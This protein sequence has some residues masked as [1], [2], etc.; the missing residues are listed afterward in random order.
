MSASFAPQNLQSAPPLAPDADPAVRSASAGDRL[1]VLQ[2]KISPTASLKR[3]K[4]EKLIKEHGSPP[5]VRVTAGGR[6]VPSDLPPLG[7]P[8][9]SRVAPFASAP[10]THPMV[11]ASFQGPR[12][13]DMTN[14]VTPNGWVGSNADGSLCQL[15]DGRAVPLKYEN[16]MLQLLIAA[17]NMPDMR[18]PPSFPVMPVNP[19]GMPQLMYAPSAGT[20]SIP[21]PFLNVQPLQ[22]AAE[23]AEMVTSQCMDVPTQIQRLEHCYA[24]LQHDYKELEKADVAEQEFGAHGDRQGYIAKRKE[25]VVATDKLR[26]LIKELKQGAGMSTSSDEKPSSRVLNTLPTPPAFSLSEH[27]IEDRGRYKQYPM[28]G[29]GSEL[30]SHGSPFMSTFASTFAPPSH[31]IYEQPSAFWHGIEAAPALVQLR[32]GE[33]MQNMPSAPLFKNVSEA[34]KS[35]AVEIKPP[36]ELQRE[37]QRKQSS[38]NPTSPTYE[39]KKYSRSMTPD[40]P[41]P[42]TFMPPS[43]SRIA[44]PQQHQ[45]VQTDNSW[46]HECHSE[47][48]QPTVEL[49]D[50]PHR[51]WQSVSSATSAA[52]KDFFPQNTHEHSSTGY[53]HGGTSAAS[54]SANQ[55][56]GAGHNPT[57]PDKSWRKTFS[58]SDTT[59][60]LC[61]ENSHPRAPHATPAGSRLSS[62]THGCLPTLV[63]IKSGSPTKPA[64]TQTPRHVP[65][66]ISVPSSMP[67]AQH[68][69]H[70]QSGKQLAPATQYGDKLSDQLTS[71]YLAG[72]AVGSRDENPWPK[73]RTDP[74]FGRGYLDGRERAQNLSAASSLRRPDQ[75]SQTANSS[76]PTLTSQPGGIGRTSQKTSPDGSDI[77]LPV[78]AS[79]GS[80]HGVIGDRMG[81]TAPFGTSKASEAFTAKVDERALQ[82]LDHEGQRP[83][84]TARTTSTKVC[85]PLSRSSSFRVSEYAQPLSRNDGGMSV[86]G[87]SIYAR[88]QGMTSGVA[89]FV[90]HSGN[91]GSGHTSGIVPDMT[92]V[93]VPHQSSARNFEAR[94]TVSIAPTRQNGRQYGSGYDGTMDDLAELMEPFSMTAA[95]EGDKYSKTGSSSP[96]KGTQQHSNASGAKVDGPPNKSPSPAKAMLQ[97]IARKVPGQKSRNKGKTA[98]DEEGTDVVKDK[99]DLQDVQTMGANDKKKWRKDWRKRF[100]NIRTKE[101]EEVAR[102]QRE[103]PF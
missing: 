95:S 32:G 4:V 30:F 69:P 42:P 85:Y 9:Y 34:R 26:K 27:S 23:A 21:S 84:L 39:P 86:I 14:Q 56:F 8:R 3:T 49:D 24:K 79:D 93:Y 29:G 62:F 19:F 12:L 15:I 5:G 51:N 102:Y 96:I 82:L 63:R 11:P 76:S 72:F 17:P 43:P 16:G 25:F 52:T 37:S 47:S 53:M 71:S 91:Q 46:H 101:D 20:F 1:N 75:F 6:I 18:S 61:N 2:K 83:S 48:E 99:K 80:Y 98:N 100:N 64:T 10:S 54:R 55:A 78:H 89:P 33:S 65:L 40:Y 68:S 77:V 92:R 88:S 59:S 36:T 38:L 45:A 74:E 103:N 73:L 81:G 94:R 70:Q 44:S 90:A 66:P 60:P 41:S 22:V 87:H 50:D 13:A 35:H 57:T 67:R 7:G 97:E 58:N 31:C 28:L